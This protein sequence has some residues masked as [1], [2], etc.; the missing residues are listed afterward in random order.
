VLFTQDGDYF[1]RTTAVAAS[2]TNPGVAAVTITLSTPLGVNN[3]ALITFHVEQSSATNVAVWISD[4]ATSDQ[5]PTYGNGL[6]NLIVG[7]AVASGL[8]AAI[9]TTVRTNTSAQIRYRLSASDAN[10]A[11]RWSTRGWLDR[12]NQDA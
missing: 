10:T 1:I 6:T 3:H 5:A 2:S 8:A 12:R 4:L 7:A 11:V 9:T